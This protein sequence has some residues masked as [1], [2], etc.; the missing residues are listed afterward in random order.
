M[1]YRLAT[2]H[3]SGGNEVVIQTKPDMWTNSCVNASTVKAQGEAVQDS[4]HCDK[5]R[6]FAHVRAWRRC[7]HF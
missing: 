1:Q 4:C 6:S 7:I 5:Q 3:H 2:T